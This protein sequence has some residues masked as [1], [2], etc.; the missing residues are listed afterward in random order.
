[1]G[2]PNQIFNDGMP[3][4]DF[5][6]PSVDSTGILST[7]GYPLYERYLPYYGPFYQVDKYDSATRRDEKQNRTYGS[8]NTCYSRKALVTAYPDCSTQWIDYTI[9]DG[10][11]TYK[12]NRLS[13]L[14]LVYRGC[15]FNDNCDYD[16]QGRPV[17]HW[18]TG[19]PS[20]VAEI[21][22]GLAAQEIYMYINLSDAWGSVI[23]PNEICDC[24]MSP[25]PGEKEP[26]PV[27]IPSPVTFPSFPKF[28]LYPHEYGCEDAIW[29]YKFAS[30][31]EGGDTDPLCVPP[32]SLYA[33]N[34]RQPYTTYGF[35]R[36]LCGKETD[37]HRQVITNG[38]AQVVQDGAYR[39]TTPTSG[40][41][42]PM[43]W[44][45][46]NP[47]TH[48][49]GVATGR[50][51]ASGTQPYWG[52]VDNNGRLVAPYFR[53]KV[54]YH[55]TCATS[56]AYL[57]F[58]TCSTRQNGWPTDRVPFLVEIDHNDSCVGCASE[59][60]EPTGLVLTLQS[61]NTSYS[62]SPES[63]EAYGYTHCAYKGIAYD[64][65]YSCASGF[66]LVC[67]SIPD[68]ERYNEPYTGETC[69]CINTD[70]SLTPVLLEGT[71]KVIGWK[72]IG[73][74]NNT[75]IRLPAACSQSNDNDFL[76]P[77]PA[78]NPIYGFSTYGSFRLAC[79]GFHNYLNEFDKPGCYYWP[80]LTSPVESLYAYGS[81][82][83]HFPSANS[84]L[85]LVAKFVIVSSGIE[86]LFEAL[87]DSCINSVDPSV[88]IPNLE[89]ENS[90][91]MIKQKLSRNAFGCPT[92]RTEYG[93]KITASGFYPCQACPSPAT[94]DCSCAG[95]ECDDCNDIISYNGVDADQLPPPYRNAC[96]CDCNLSPMRIWSITDAVETLY[97]TFESGVCSGDVIAVSWS[98]AY[99]STEIIYEL[100]AS[101]GLFGYGP[102]TATSTSNCGWDNGVNG[103]ASGVKYNFSTP[104]VSSCGSLDPDTCDSSAC[105]DSNVGKGTCGDP[106]PWTGV[107][108]DEGVEV[109]R[110]AC[111]PEIMVV[112]KIVCSGDYFNLY[113]AREYHSH[114]RD[115]KYLDG[116]TCV[117]KQKGAYRYTDGLG[118]GQCVAIPFFTPSDS[119]TPAYY[120]EL[121]N[122]GS[123]YRGICMAHYPSG[124]YTNQDF[125]FSETPVASGQDR[126]WNYFNIYYESG[127]PSSKYHSA[128]Y[129]GD[130]DGSPPE[131]PCVNGTSYSN[132][133]VFG[134]GLYASPSG[135]FGV[136]WTNRKH[137]CIQ[138]SRECGADF[139]CNKMFFPRRKYKPGTIVTK[140]GSLQL[141]SSTART[142]VGDWYTGYQDFGSNPSVILE[143][144]NSKFIDACDT[145]IQ[146]EIVNSVGLDDVIITVDNYLP[147]MGIRTDLFRY[148]LDV[149]SCVHVS[150]GECP[151]G[152]IPLHSDFTIRVGLHAP[153]TYPTDKTDSMGYYLDRAT[154]E[155]DD[156]CLFNPFKILVDVQCCTSNV[157]RQNYPNDDPTNLEY[158]LEGVPSWSCGGFVKSPVCGCQST[159][160]GSVIGAYELAPRPVCLQMGAARS[161]YADVQSTGTQTYYQG[162][163][164]PSPCRTGVPISVNTATVQAGDARLVFNGTDAGI[165]YEIGTVG[166]P[167]GCLCVDDFTYS[168]AALNGSILA[169]T[170]QM[171]VSTGNVPIP[172]YECGD[173][174]Y[175]HKDAY[176][177]PTCCTY[178]TLCDVLASGWRIPKNGCAILRDS[179][180][181]SFTNEWV[182]CTGCLP[183]TPYSD[184]YPAIL[185]ATITEDI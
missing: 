174:Y 92:Y 97:Q 104:A 17:G 100:G 18:P 43:Y 47:Y 66:S 170:G 129:L 78:Y 136:D 109:R 157:R 133:A 138:D 90:I 24:S 114:T 185:K 23:N 75:Y 4:R 34:V 33:C 16:S 148:N 106:I 48:E 20:S 41:N 89:E 86:S 116:A 35:M 19:I 154:A 76:Q 6:Y 11:A 122:D 68:F 14:G 119:V 101:A 96:K 159:V 21:K 63:T 110:R 118:S 140:F 182:D 3:R 179:N 55:T 46:T 95:I 165:Q 61:M 93:C 38:F 161:S 149:K 178:Y 7:S 126:L 127:Y 124:E 13:R 44:E 51:S 151:A 162:A 183:A 12:I 150:S 22:R 91:A 50:L 54:D 146:A 120:T 37:D 131:D 60:M 5:R 132:D 163:C 98:G 164:S 77:V 31:C 72:S 26:I 8:N 184:C 160:C 107:V 135:R 152:W 9:C 30:E 85:N 130:P 57:N 25:P 115:W 28:D 29:Q 70:I 42:E 177:A 166:T 142:K 27:I 15:N 71:S 137:S 79:A 45:F 49:S 123:G 180:R 144:E 117:W 111:Y 88:T 99:G 83:R 121:T 158:I 102:N 147:L 172:A 87:P 52:L 69:G 94:A 56:G 153:K 53:T 134:T 113:V 2:Q 125:T 62:H 175:I 155:Q 139:F 39:N 103:L 112:N 1:M 128:I 65:T 171:I 173:Y 10:E 64:P 59:Q 145:S 82:S 32:S 105:L 176:L 81:C 80:G 67:P 143:A 84:D 58:D 141:C 169:C 167:V 181:G 108:P 168:P 40:N 36:S 73:P 156:N 74:G